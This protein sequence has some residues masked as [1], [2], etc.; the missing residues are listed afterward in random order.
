MPARRGAAGEN[1]T[2]ASDY[3]RQVAALRQ[4]FRDLGYVEGQS[5]ALEFRWADGRYERLA[6]L[7]AELIRLQ[8]DAIISSGPGTRVLKSA[9]ATIPIVM[10]VSLDAQA[11]GL[12]GSLNHP[13]GNI[14]GSTAFGPELRGSPQPGQRDIS[15]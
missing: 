10:A 5:I 15:R 14:T 11:A 3:A 8:P 2:S 12:V 7:A 13:G 6:P 4:G 9:T 1:P